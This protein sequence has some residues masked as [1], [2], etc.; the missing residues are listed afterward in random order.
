MFPF[1]EVGTV[2]CLTPTDVDRPRL[3]RCGGSARGWEDG[4][5]LCSEVFIII[6]LGFRHQDRVKALFEIEKW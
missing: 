4:T 2:S 1:R 3:S 6:T 5:T